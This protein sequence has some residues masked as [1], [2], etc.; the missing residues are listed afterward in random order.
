MAVGDYARWP[1]QALQ[2]E[3][4][5]VPITLGFASGVPSVEDPSTGVSVADT[6]TGKFTL[7]VPGSYDLKV[8]VT[9]A[10]AAGTLSFARAVKAASASAGTV[11]IETLLEATK[12][13][14]LADPADDDQ[15]HVLA[16]CRRIAS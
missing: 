16:I 5:L 10:P 9:A 7:T 6:A 11:I 3:I 4:V 2:R 14:A 15:V 1:V 12:T 8:I 13:T